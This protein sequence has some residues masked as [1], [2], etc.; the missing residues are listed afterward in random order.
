M[1]TYFFRSWMDAIG[2]T[3]LACLFITALTALAAGYI[4]EI[5]WRTRPVVALEGP[6]QIPVR[7]R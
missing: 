4:E 5:D 6:D 1:K 2:Q 3:I 7:I